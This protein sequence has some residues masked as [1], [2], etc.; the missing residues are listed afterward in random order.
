M[1]NAYA[2]IDYD[3]EVSSGALTLEAYRNQIY[4]ETKNIIE[5][6]LNTARSSSDPELSLVAASYDSGTNVDEAMEG[7]FKN[8]V[9][10]EIDSNLEQ[11]SGVLPSAELSNIRDAC[12]V[13]ADI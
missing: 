1:L 12:Y 10:G 7:K 4:Q 9:R 6:E 11:Y 8:I 3:P 13:F 2:T 5:R